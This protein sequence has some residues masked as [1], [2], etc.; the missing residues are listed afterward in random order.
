MTPSSWLPGLRALFERRPLRRRIATRHSPTRRRQ[1][2]FETLEDRLVFAL[3][4]EIIPQVI[5]EDG[6]F[7][8]ATVYRSGSLAQPLTVTLKSS[9]PVEIG[10]PM[11]VEIPANMASKNFMITLGNDSFLDGPVLVTVTASATGHD[12]A[13]DSLTV[14][15]DD[16]AVQ[17]PGV[18]HD[19]YVIS[20]SA[21]PG[22]YDF[23]PGP[24]G[25]SSFGP[26]RSVPFA[27]GSMVQTVAADTLVESIEFL[28]VDLSKTY[29]LTGWAKSGDEFGQQY[30]VGNEQSFGFQSYDADHLLI[31]PEH[32]LR[33]LGSSDTRLAAPLNP[34]DTVIRLVNASGWSNANGSSAAS[35]GVAWYGYQDSHGTTYGEYAYTR[36]VRI[37]ESGLWSPGG[38]NG[39]VITLN[40]PWSGPALAAGTAVRNTGAGSVANWSALNSA[41]VAG[42]WTW[43]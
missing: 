10:V 18:S 19:R 5:D 24:S 30:D 11:T 41:A 29:A 22:L 39:N 20:R 16:F 37:G 8:N 2:S 42:D 12:D 3:A 35:R 4:V 23:T 28:P 25:S 31:R 27:A 7:F 9:D 43:T 34:G 32:V 17:L 33:H 26:A 15:N 40:S 36:N 14:L 38:V 13:K 21:A 6:I 1:R